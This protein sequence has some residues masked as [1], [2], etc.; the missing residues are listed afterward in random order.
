VN[1]VRTKCQIE[2]RFGLTPPGSAIMLLPLPCFSSTL[3][4][5]KR[6]RWRKHRSSSGWLRFHKHQSWLFRD[7]SAPA[8]SVAKLGLAVL[9]V[10]N[11]SLEELF[12]GCSRCP[13]KLTVRLLPRFSLFQARPNFADQCQFRTFSHRK[14][15]SDIRQ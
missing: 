14:K 11:M 8:A 9:K 12:A 4:I 2:R 1:F 13:A 6:N 7:G 5:F 15:L 10:C 3:C